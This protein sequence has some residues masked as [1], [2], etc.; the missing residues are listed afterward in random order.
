MDENIGSL[1]SL[2]TGQCT[3]AMKSKMSGLASFQN[4][5]VGNDAIAL[6]KAINEIAFKFE[7]H[8]NI[9]VSLWN[10]KPQITNTFQN[11]MVLSQ[12][13]ENFVANDTITSQTGCGIWLD[14][15]TVTE[16]INLQTMG[17]TIAAASVTEL[18]LA[19]VAA[20]EK[21]QGVAFLMQSRKQYDPLR[22]RLANQFMMGEDR[23]PLT[24]TEAYNVLYNWKDESGT[25]SRP[26][27]QSEEIGH[28]SFIQYG[29]GDVGGDN[30]GE[31]KGGG[32]DRTELQCYR[33][34]QY[35]EHYANEYPYMEE[36]AE[37]MKKATRGGAQK[38]GAMTSMHL[39]GDESDG[40]KL[41]Q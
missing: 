2:V 7:A 41:W 32:K 5:D 4:M 40:G 12:F 18:H 8:D 36:E 39:G 9:H 31:R 30:N 22:A 16:E 1:Y 26:T 35:E 33:C 20:K 6:L 23:Y 29:G 21:Q 34:G 25:A 19:T 14:E 10:L 37:K 38:K 27:V 15:K 28:M 11:G 17:L 13:M 3:D 24:V